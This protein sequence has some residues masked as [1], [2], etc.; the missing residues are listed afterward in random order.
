LQESVRWNPLLHATKP[1]TDLAHA[2]S[3]SSPLSKIRFKTQNIAPPGLPVPFSAKIHKD[4]LAT[5][6]KKA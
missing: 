4:I 5:R 6:M 1:Q 2:A 3:L